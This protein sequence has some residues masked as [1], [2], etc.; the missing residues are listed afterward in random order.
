MQHPFNNVAGS[1]YV[2]EPYLIWLV[3]RDSMKV[4]G[5]LNGCK[6][7]YGPPVGIIQFLLQSGLSYQ[8]LVYHYISVLTKAPKMARWS[9]QFPSSIIERFSPILHV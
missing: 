1:T 4:G 5:I 6:Q 2:V 8:K 3:G 9:L 7:D